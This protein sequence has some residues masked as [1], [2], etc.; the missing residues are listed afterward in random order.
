M[1]TLSEAQ[2]PNHT[3][4]LQATDKAADRRTPQNRFLAKGEQIYGSASNLGIMADG[5]LKAT[6]GSQPHNN[7]QPFL[8]LNFIIA[9]VGLYP[10][11]S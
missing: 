8:V 2:M 7:L 4:T 3:H 6:G 10:S 11:R 9:L 5:A 1:V